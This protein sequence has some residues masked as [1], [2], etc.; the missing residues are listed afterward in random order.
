LNQSPNPETSFFLAPAAK[1]HSTDDFESI[2]IGV[3]LQ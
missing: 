1:D 3:N 2:I